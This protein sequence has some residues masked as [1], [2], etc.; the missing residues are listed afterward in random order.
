MLQDVVFGR[1][2]FI[3]SCIKIIPNDNNKREKQAKAGIV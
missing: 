1:D 2:L 3:L